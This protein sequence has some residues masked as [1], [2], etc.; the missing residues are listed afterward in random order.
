[1]GFAPNL[2]REAI[3][4]LGCKPSGWLLD[5][6]CGTGTTLVECGLQ[7]I[8]AI[9][10][11]ANPFSA[12]C[13]KVKTDWNVDPD[14]IDSTLERLYGLADCTNAHAMNSTALP[15][16]VRNGWVSPHIWNKASTIYGLTRQVRNLDRRYLLQLAVISAV[17]EFCANV[18]FGPEIYKRTRTHR[19]GLRWAVS[20]KAKQ[21]AEDLRGI[22]API[23][24]SRI[25]ALHGDSRDLQFLVDKGFA[26]Q[27]Q[28]I[29]TSPPYPTEHDYSR[30]SRIE[31]ELGGF[32]KAHGDLQAIKRMQIRSNSKTVYADDRDWEHVKTMRSVNRLVRTLEDLSSQKSYSFAHRYPKVI[33]NYFGGLARHL[34]S[35][36]EL[37]PSGGLCLYVLG[38]QRSYL[39]VLV[40]TPDIFIEIACKRL[41]SFKLVK[42]AV[43]RLRRGTSGTIT[44][45]REEAVVLQRR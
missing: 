13:S 21:I 40:P 23:Q 39:G 4:D 37:M 41:Q 10:V 44:N 25:E 18:A 30:I 43:V 42:R 34:S 12:F 15:Q 17:K 14:E 2:V 28:W 7:G 22:E 16:A 45:L 29:I 19:V 1:M 35:V 6:F 5:P 3:A 38:E 31:L 11:D 33:A 8:N 36:A 26:G 20:Y 27:V 9:G 24:K 32:L